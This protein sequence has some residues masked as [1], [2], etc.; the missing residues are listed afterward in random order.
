MRLHLSSSVKSDITEIPRYIAQDSPHHAV[1][2]VRLLRQGMRQAADHPKLFRIR[3]E[4]AP[5]ARQNVVGSYVI[6][7]RIVDDF[8][9]IERI[10]HGSRELPGLLQGEQ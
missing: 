3:T 7:F 1:K 9:R 6:L 5:D 2:V 4:L 10:V 8:V